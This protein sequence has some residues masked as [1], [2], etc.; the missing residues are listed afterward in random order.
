MAV[1]VHARLAPLEWGLCGLRTRYSLH[2]GVLHSCSLASDEVG[3][4]REIDLG[5]WV[6]A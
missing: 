1:E 6:V 2:C 5:L 4:G 3:S